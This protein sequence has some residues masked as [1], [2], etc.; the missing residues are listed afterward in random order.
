MTVVFICV[1]TTVFGPAFP[2]L[3]VPDL[4]FDILCRA[5]EVDALEREAG[6]GL[7]EGEPFD[8][9]ESGA[10]ILERDQITLAPLRLCAPRPKLPQA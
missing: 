9:S 1:T 4:S 8:W 10:V 7:A 6:Q 5:A 2:D 3:S